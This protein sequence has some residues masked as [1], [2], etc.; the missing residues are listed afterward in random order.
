M[1]NEKLQSEI[2]TFLRF[3]LIVGVV[4]IHSQITG[5]TIN[6]ENVLTSTS[7]QIFSTLQYL[8]SNILSRVAVPLFFSISGFLFFYKTNSFTP[9]NYKQKIKKRVSSIFL[10]YLYWNIIILIITFLSQLLLG[11][12]MS[13]NSKLITDYSFSDFIYIFYDTDLVNAVPAGGY[14]ICYQFWFLRD[15][16]ITMLFSPLIYIA[17][18]YLREY[19][20]LLLT[21]LWFFDYWPNSI[22][23]FN[24][25]AFFFFSIGA[26]FSIVKVSFIKISEVLLKPSILFYIVTTIGILIFRESEWITYMSK[27]NILAGIILTINISRYYLNREVKI[28]SIYSESSFFIYAYHGHF[29]TLIIK[30]FIVIFNPKSNIS[31][32]L[33]YSMSPTI[34]IT[35]GICL[36]FILRKSLPKITSALTG[37]R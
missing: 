22:I 25:L 33:V 4:L 23:G 16:M 3:P 31:L 21:V 6:G 28:H 13:G 9:H 35:V 1:N 11:N 5:I 18:R 14:P 17:V 36:Y 30:L 27:I 8:I 37:A 34:V 20:L 32:L 12:L 7:F 2:I 19:A 29:L 10:P 15:L 26:Y 24:I